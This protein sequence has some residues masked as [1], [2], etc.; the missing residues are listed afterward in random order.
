MLETFSF[1]FL[2]YFQLGF[3]KP[4]TQIWLD[5]SMSQENPPKSEKLQLC[6]TGTVSEMKTVPPSTEGLEE[7][8]K[9]Q[10]AY[11]QVC[12]AFHSISLQQMYHAN[13]NPRR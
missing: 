13:K 3:A 1:F 12:E 10:L 2:L 8:L 6:E 5:T 7:R 11:L 4:D 9:P